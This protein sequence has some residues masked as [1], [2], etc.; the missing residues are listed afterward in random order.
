MRTV[1]GRVKRHR[2]FSN[3]SELRHSG[4]RR[5]RPNPN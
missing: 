3:F 5:A 4:T 2:C 1:S